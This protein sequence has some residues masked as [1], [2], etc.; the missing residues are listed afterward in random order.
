M[1][2]SKFLNHSELNSSLILR[3]KIGPTSQDYS[4]EAGYCIRKVQRRGVHIM[5][6]T[7][8]TKYRWLFTFPESEVPLK[9]LK[10]K[11]T[12]S[13]DP[14]GKCNMHSHGACSQQ[15]QAVCSRASDIQRPPIKKPSNYKFLL[16]C[17]GQDTH[18]HQHQN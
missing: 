5:S 10:T 9:N 7:V 18:Q 16:L 8:I 4:E 11:R 14:P 1:T 13:W 12:K 15:F 17:E 6:A 2:S 3:R